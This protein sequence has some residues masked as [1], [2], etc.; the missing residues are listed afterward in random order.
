[1]QAGIVEDITTSNYK[2]EYMYNV[3]NWKKRA[4]RTQLKMGE[5]KVVGFAELCM[6]KQYMFY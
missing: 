5:G 6:V 3:Y 4:T 2:V 1:L